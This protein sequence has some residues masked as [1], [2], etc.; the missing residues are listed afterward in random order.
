MRRLVSLSLFLVL[1][2]AGRSAR[3]QS[4]AQAPFG[5]EVGQAPAVEIGG[6]FEATHANAPPGQCGCFWMQGGGVAINLSVRP[7]WSAMTD[8][9]F[10][11]NGKIG[12]T[13][14]Q[15]SV[16]NY[17]FGTRYTYRN[18]TRITPYGQ[19]LAGISHV[20]SNFEIYSSKNNYLAA[21]GGLGFEYYVTPRISA[22]PLEAD[23]VFSRAINGVNTRQNNLRVGIGVVYRIAPK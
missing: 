19:A 17:L 14:E 21:E 2:V 16:F 6:Q 22:V 11:H 4:T 7:A 18:S 23:W 9:Y 15:L 5:L 10:A 20:G 8:V 12:A 3:A 1:V 13:D